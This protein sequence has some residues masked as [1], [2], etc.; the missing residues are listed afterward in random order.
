M[1]NAKNVPKSVHHT[2][3]MSRDTGESINTHNG[4]HD[5]PRL[6]TCSSLNSRARFRHAGDHLPHQ[7]VL[8]RHYRLDSVL[9]ICDVS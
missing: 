2:V 1:A 4:Q 3:Q 7:C 8:Q 5:S 9:L 6:N